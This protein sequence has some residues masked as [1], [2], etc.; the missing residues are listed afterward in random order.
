MTA[1]NKTVHSI[2]I[3]GYLNIH[4]LLT[5]KS[6]LAHGHKFVLWI[7]DGALEPAAEKYIF[8]DPDFEIR[9]AREVL[10][11][12]EV[13]YYE[14]LGEKFRFGGIAER[15]KAELL[16][17]F[18]GWHVDLDV[19]C[20]KPLDFEAEYVLRPHPQGIV[21]NIIKA[22]AQSQLAAE[23]VAWTKQIDSENR[24]WE[25][26]FRGL[27]VSVRRYGLQKYIVGPEVLG[28]DLPEWWQDFLF[29]NG[30]VPSDSTY[31]LHWCSAINE[32]CE[33]GSFYYSLLERYGLFN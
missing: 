33:E 6:F 31:A 2:W 9:D 25:K 19:T 26:S 8:S 4:H 11:E 23:Y 32:G 7:F 29:N 16:Y 5:I 15:L 14:H 10:P 18:G 27:N 1:E 30:K 3:S 12:S 13:Y 21:G 20:L 24:D 17:K 22:P 28:M